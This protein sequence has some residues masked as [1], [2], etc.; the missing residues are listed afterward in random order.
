MLHM[1][2]HYLSTAKNRIHST[3]DSQSLRIDAKTFSASDLAVG[4]EPTVG[5]PP[6]KPDTVTLR[7]LGVR[8]HGSLDQI[9]DGQRTQIHSF[10]CLGVCLFVCVCVCLC[11]Q[12]SCY[13]PLN[14]VF[15]SFTYNRLVVKD[16]FSVKIMT[17][18]ICI[19]ILNRKRPCGLI[20]GLNYFDGVLARGVPMYV[21][22]EREIT[23]F[24]LNR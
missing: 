16:G 21:T 12:V 19:A 18:L 13:E 20:R 6:W 11:R 17:P 1:W 9:Q 14:S 22:W 2:Y 10:L 4:R 15:R 3:T 24:N 23:S 7:H 5:G 8:I